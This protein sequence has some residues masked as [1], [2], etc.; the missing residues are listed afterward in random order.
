MYELKV[1]NPKDKNVW[2]QAIRAAVVDCPAFE[3][4]D[5]QLT[6]EQ[7]QQQLDLKHVNIREIICKYFII[8]IIIVPLTTTKNACK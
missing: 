3:E 6:A 5:D 8:Q 2:I 4:A 7:R 1:Q